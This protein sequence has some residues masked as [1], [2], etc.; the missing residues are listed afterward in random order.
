LNEKLGYGLGLGVEA[1][2]AVTFYLLVCSNAIENS[3][4][5]HM[6]AT[7]SCPGVPLFLEGGRLEEE[8]YCAWI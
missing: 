8:I 2:L 6:T 1:I 7:K 4:S 3:Y 5:I